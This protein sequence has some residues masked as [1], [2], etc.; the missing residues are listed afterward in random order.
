MKVVFLR[1]IFFITTKRTVYENETMCDCAAV[2]SVFGHGSA[3][4]GAVVF[5]AR[6]VAG[7]PAHLRPGN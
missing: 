1:R 2:G 7:E 6:H 3:G 5:V 4:A